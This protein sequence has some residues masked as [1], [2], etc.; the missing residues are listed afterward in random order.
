MART[1]SIFYVLLPAT[2]V[3][4]RSRVIRDTVDV[5]SH[6]ME[7][8]RLMAS[9][10][11]VGKQCGG[12]AS[13]ESSRRRWYCGTFYHPCPLP[14]TDDWGELESSPLCCCSASSW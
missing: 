9:R 4:I 6:L 12:T 11:P 3:L 8:T 10:V 13:Y 2:R 5:T 1:D 14:L 7:A